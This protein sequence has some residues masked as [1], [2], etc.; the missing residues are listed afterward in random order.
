MT[1]CCSEEAEGIISLYVRSVGFLPCSLYSAISF[2]PLSGSNWVPVPEI[3]DRFPKGFRD[4]EEEGDL[5]CFIFINRRKANQSKKVQ[6]NSNLW[7]TLKTCL[8]MGY[9]LK[10]DAIG[11]LRILKKERNVT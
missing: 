10:N 5:K 9:V 8:T 7:D 1:N 4:L 6:K 2:R 3:A 11:E